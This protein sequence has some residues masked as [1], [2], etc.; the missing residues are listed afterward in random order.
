M[1]T[2]V[3]ISRQQRLYV[4]QLEK[5]LSEEKRTQRLLV[6]HVQELRYPGVPSRAST[7][8]NPTRTE[9]GVGGTFDEH[10]S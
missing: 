5:Q 6:T 4:A 3:A 7:P 1:P 8:Q 9:G 10:D 2:Y